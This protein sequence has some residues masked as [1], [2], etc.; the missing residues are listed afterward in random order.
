MKSMFYT[1][2]SFWADTRNQMHES[3]WIETK[4]MSAIMITFRYT[5]MSCGMLAR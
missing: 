5:L 4:R 2:R 1:Q 3:T